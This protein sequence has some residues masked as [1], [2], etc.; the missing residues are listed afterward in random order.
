MSVHIDEDVWSWIPSERDLSLAPKKTRTN[1]QERVKLSPVKAPVT[2]LPKI[3]RKKQSDSPRYTNK[4]DT[5]SEN[6]R[7]SDR[8]SSYHRESRNTHRSDS[9]RFRSPSRHISPT[10][11]SRKFF[12][13]RVDTQASKSLIHRTEVP[14]VGI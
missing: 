14:K 11:T 5:S 2:H 7:Y 3:P 13:S 9:D 1:S 8:H 6:T 4:P 10:S 12:L